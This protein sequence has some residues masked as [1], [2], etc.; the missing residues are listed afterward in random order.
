MIKVTKIIET[1]GAC[2][3]Q[4]SGRTDDDKYLYIR[5]RWGFLRIELEG[6]T[7]FEGTFGDSLDGVMTFE[8]LVEHT[9]QEIDFSEAK[10]VASREEV[11]ELHYF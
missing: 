2:P 10:W 7:I 3:S 9:A 6:D 8:E 1:C 4:W 11:H 5:Y